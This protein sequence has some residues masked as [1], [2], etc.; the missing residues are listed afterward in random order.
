MCTRYGK[1]NNKIDAVMSRMFHGNFPLFEAVYD[2]FLI[3]NAS[4]L[5]MQTDK[6][7]MV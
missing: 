4:F 5:L 2:M 3:I 7:Y 6:N 1:R